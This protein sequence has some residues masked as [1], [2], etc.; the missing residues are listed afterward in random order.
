[1]KK[2]STFDWTEECT[3]SFHL[4]KK[5]IASE[6]VLVHYNPQLPIKLICDASQ[7]GIGA[8]IFHTMENNEDRPIAFASK[9]LSKAQS[10]YSTI[11][12][13]ALAIY[14]GV[15][16]FQ[17][18]L[19]GRRFV[20]QTDH[21]PL[22]SIFGSKRGIPTMAASRLQRWAMYLSSFDFEIQ[23]IVGKSNVNAD[24]LS[25]LPTNRNDFVDDENDEKTT[26]L[27]FITKISPIDHTT[28]RQE[29]ANDSIL[30]TVIEFMRT[31]WPSKE[32]TD[33]SMKPFVCR[34]N[35]LTIEDDILL[36]GH[37]VI[38]PSSLHKKILEQLHSSHPG[39]SKMKA[40]ARSH[41][42]WPNLDREIEALANNCHQCVQSRQNP[43]KTYSPWPTDSAP[44]QRIHI[45]YLGPFANK[46]FLIV[47]DSY[48]KW[49]EVYPT[50]STTSGPTIE[51]LR[52]CFARFGLPDVIVSD[53]GRQFVSSQFKEF[54]TRNSIKHLTIAPYSPQSNGAAE[55]A[56]K[57]FKVGMTKALSDPKNNG[58]SM[59]TLTNRYLFF[60][61]SS[62]HATTLE[63]P[64]KR[65]FGREM[66]T[67]FDRIKPSQVTAMCE[68]LESAKYTIG[69]NVIV[70]NYQHNNQKWQPAKIVKV[71]GKKMFKCTTAE[72]EWTRHENQIRPVSSE[73]ISNDHFFSSSV[74]TS[75][76]ATTATANQEPTCSTNSQ[77]DTANT[78]ESIQITVL[79]RKMKIL[80]TPSVNSLLRMKTTGSVT[81]K[82]KMTHPN[83]SES[84]QDDNRIEHTRHP[85]D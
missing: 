3:N 76:S 14:F 6:K 10:N 21:K 1:M 46:M 82:Q 13:E 15:N 32:S 66:R 47:L 80:R 48:S 25:R 52:D 73:I 55:N 29:T 58:E 62:T 75:D 68:Q 85:K 50:T 12:R 5:V 71:L 51:K 19:I 31:D 77:V 64:Y 39:I 83:R 27:N 30:S 35:E 65:M 42:W 16:K 24:F 60:Y 4:V 84:Q 43:A 74:S 78:I 53:N 54:C 9:S 79:L 56:V 20:L 17:H 38:V 72:G 59:E 11:D 44:F 8:A 7:H 61:R 22:T 41:F 37:R 23:Y 34:A 26:Y 67:H 57:S 70:R 2:T 45:D 18:Y 36:W 81:L 63:T 40:K 49:V 33:D 28:I 69:D